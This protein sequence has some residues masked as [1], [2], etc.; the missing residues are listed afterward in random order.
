MYKSKTQKRRRKE[1][2][3]APVSR[4][5][6]GFTGRTFSCSSLRFL[7][8]VATAPGFTASGKA[9]RGDVLSGTGFP[10]TRH[11]GRCHFP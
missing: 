2:R 10:G 3:R 4:R 9:G 5:E 6:R 8:E 1:G 7:L 11:R